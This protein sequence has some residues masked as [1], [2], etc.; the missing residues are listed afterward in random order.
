MGRETLR[1]V[2]VLPPAVAPTAE[3]AEGGPVVVPAAVPAKLAAAA[4]PTA[5]ADLPMLVIPCM[6]MPV[7]PTLEDGTDIGMEAGVGYLSE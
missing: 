4:A 2:A 6:P 7:V 5:G 1:E 3:A